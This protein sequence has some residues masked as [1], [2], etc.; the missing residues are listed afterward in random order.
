MEIHKDRIENKKEFD[1]A[2]KAIYK[3]VELD[4]KL[5]DSLSIDTSSILISLCF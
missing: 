2:I 4:K 5:Y 1:N 3:G